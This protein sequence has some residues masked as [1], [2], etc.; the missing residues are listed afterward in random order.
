M[1]LADVHFSIR[2]GALIAGI[3]GEVDMSNADQLGAAVAD[4]T[5]NHLLGVVLDLTAVD[6]L[7]SAGIHLIYAL[8]ESLRMRGQELRLVVPEASPVNESMRL[9]GVRRHLRVAEDVDEALRALGTGE[10]DAPTGA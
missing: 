6:H 10:A 5:A 2:D 8:R 1:K 3:V 4:A 9:A 7:D